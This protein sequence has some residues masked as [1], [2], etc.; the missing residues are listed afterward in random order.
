[1]RGVRI[2]RE[3]RV[4]HGYRRS[5]LRAG[6]GPALVLIHGIGD[7]GETWRGVIPALARHHTVIAPD[8]L[9]HGRSDKPRADYSVGGFAN[10]LR[11]LLVLLGIPTATVVGHSLGG[12]VALQFAYHYPERLERLVLVSSGG[13]GAE[14]TPLLRAASLPGAE[15][16][17][18]AS[19]LPPVRVPVVLAAHLLAKLRVLEDDDV[20]EVASIWAGLRDRATRSAFLR[21]LRSVVDVRGQSVTSRDRLYLAQ[22]LPTL[23]VWGDRDPIVPLAQA[24]SVA[25]ELPGAQ[26]EILPGAGHLPHR[27]DPGRF[28]EIVLG[29]LERTEPK[30]HEPEAWRSLLARG[31]RAAVVP[32]AR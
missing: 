30:T 26:L 19:T 6:S 27:T 4:V 28:A 7:S 9:G 23:M 17:I 31:D 24:L 14:V 13:L 12:G 25:E 18:A 5:Y 15:L 1:M 10:G 22:T 11:D 29:F 8:L 20:A 32:I 2:V 21:T 16:V 3:Q